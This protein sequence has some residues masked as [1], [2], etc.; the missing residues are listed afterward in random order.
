MSAAGSEPSLGSGDFGETP[1][2]SVITPCFNAVRHLRDA[3]E[4]VAG[5][6]GVRVEHIVVDADSKD[7]T[8]EIL[9][10]FPAVRWISE[11]DRGQSD[12]FNKGLAMARGP[13]IGWLNADDVYEPGAIA[14]VV[15]FFREYSDAVLLNGH[16]VRVDPA[17]KPLE[18][19]PA[20]SSRF[21]LR[22]FWLK[23]YWLNHPSTF[24]RKSL[25]DEVGPIDISLHYAM[26][27]DFYLRAS[28]RHEFHD[29]DLLTT[30]MRVHPDAKTSQG[31]DNFASDVRRTFEK[32]WKPDHPWFYRYS[33][34]GVRMYAARSHLAESFIAL[35]NGDRAACR[36]ELRRA[37]TWWPMLPLLPA[38]YP[39][40]ARVLLRLAL[41]ESLYSRLP[42]PGRDAT[43]ASA[44]P[45]AAPASDLVEVYRAA[46]G[47]DAHLVK[48]SLEAAGIAA[49]VT[50]ESV[51]AM[52]PNFWWAAP[53]VLVAPA[54]AREAERIIREHKETRPT[55][56]NDGT[57]SQG[58]MHREI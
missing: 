28:L 29:I 36:A 44:T 58:P 42:R 53:R 33:I 32:V 30:R 22:H 38:F 24:Y 25:F 23:W 48:A 20:R 6:R 40:A 47:V 26:D 18:F 5:Q 35:R 11:P 55:P 21:W 4:S 41:G 7:G 13:L 43:S 56:P 46:H 27:Y 52:E 34:L 19:L 31:W 49:E 16:L 10:Q 15:Q 37:A 14:R 17:G 2:I 9:K 1:E 50:G 39:Y 3:I 12:A 51:A 8:L 45:P 54:Q 57:A